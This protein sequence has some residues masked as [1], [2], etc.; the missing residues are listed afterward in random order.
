MLKSTA[1]FAQSIS[2]VIDVDKRRPQLQ[3]FHR[4]TWYDHSTTAVS[5][6]SEGQ[7]GHAT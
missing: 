7:R 6:H 4:N 5:K 3:K 1:Q 2:D